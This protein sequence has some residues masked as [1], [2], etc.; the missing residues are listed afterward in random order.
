MGCLAHLDKRKT[1][2]TFYLVTITEEHPVSA[3]GYTSSSDSLMV[4]EAED[5]PSKD[6]ALKELILG[7]YCEVE[8]VRLNPL[9]VSDG[10]AEAF[11]YCVEEI[12]PEDY[13]VLDKYLSS[14]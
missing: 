1:I 5:I 6:K 9:T 13:A 12:P 14:I 7:W 10:H 8:V 4:L 3:E 2:M 11:V